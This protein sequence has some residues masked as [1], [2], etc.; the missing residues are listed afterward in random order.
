MHAVQEVTTAS[1][2]AAA[3]RA[4]RTAE[5]S[6]PVAALAAEAANLV[7][8]IDGVEQRGGEPVHPDHECGLTVPY[9]QKTLRQRLDA[10]LHLASHRQ[11]TSLKGALFQLYVGHVATTLIDDAPGVDDLNSAIWMRSGIGW[12]GGASLAARHAS[13]GSGRW[14]GMP[15][16]R[17][18]VAIST[19]T[20]SATWGDLRLRSQRLRPSGGRVSR[21]ATF[22][23]YLGAEAHDRR[24]FHRQAG[25]ARV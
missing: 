17:F 7:R 20:R 19:K 10:M 25:G 18:S 3:G 23:S 6:C 22:D 15:T 14:T 5:G 9:V 21:R 8:A 12:S 11:A 2:V 1:A 4:I 24:R 13:A 16:S